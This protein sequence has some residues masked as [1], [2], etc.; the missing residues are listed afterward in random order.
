MREAKTLLIVLTVLS[1]GYLFANVP[2]DPYI[3]G[4]TRVMAGL[5]NVAYSL[6]NFNQNSII[7]CIWY[8]ENNSTHAVTTNVVTSGS[9][10]TTFD[11]PYSQATLLLDVEVSYYDSNLDQEVIQFYTITIKSFLITLHNVRRAGIDGN[12]YLGP[13]PNVPIHLNI[14]ND[15]V[16]NYGDLLCTSPTLNA[17]NDLLPMTIEL[18]PENVYL[19]NNSSLKINI[20]GAGLRLWTSKNKTSLFASS[21]NDYSFPDSNLYAISSVTFY[22]E[23]IAFGASYIKVIINGEQIDSSMRYNA[24]AVMD[25]S[26]PTRLERQITEYQTL[27]GCEWSLIHQGQDIVS[28]YLHS[29]LAYAVDPQCNSFGVP[30]I[31]QKTTPYIPYSIYLEPSNY[32]GY[33][34]HY[35]NVDVFWNNNTIFETGDVISYFESS[36]WSPGYVPTSSGFGD[37]IFYSGFHA[38]Q[39]YD[40]CSGIMSGWRMY[41]SKYTAGEIFI[42]RDFQLNEGPIIL[43]FNKD[44]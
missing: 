6:A 43:R 29:S 35:T 41:K 17:D 24:Y 23:A 32:F 15:V 8:L 42:Y 44:E 3:S 25:G 39:K 16:A 5:Q 27:V 2:N 38:G 22:V 14:N 40:G 33:A 31:V 30:F 1:S 18:Y 12:N 26:Q 37:I 9:L 28:S 19:G 11:M 21:D 13:E 7:S 34:A 10:S 20:T 36:R 4:P